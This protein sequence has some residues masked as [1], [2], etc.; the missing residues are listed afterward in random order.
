MNTSLLLSVTGTYTAKM[1]ECMS[2][3]TTNDK[4]AFD[5]TTAGETTEAQQQELIKEEKKHLE[6]PAEQKHPHLYFP[7][8]ENDCYDDKLLSEMDF[9]HGMYVPALCISLCFI[10]LT[11]EGSHPG[12]STGISNP[13]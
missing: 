12:R 2:Y 11:H 3:M 6:H 10:L 1:A 13:A 9:T 4:E 5:R 8:H 7:K